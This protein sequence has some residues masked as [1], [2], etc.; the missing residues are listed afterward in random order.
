MSEILSR[1]Q[2]IRRGK[3]K[4]ILASEAELAAEAPVLAAR[5]AE[6]AQF[7]L[8]APLFGALWVLHALR[9]RHPRGWW[10][11][12]RRDAVAPTAWA[13]PWSEIPSF[14]WSEEELELLKRYPTLGELLNHRAFRATPEAVHRALLNWSTG[15]Y[16]MVLMDRIPSV[17]EVLA[18]QITGKRC[19]TLL[20]G[21]RQLAKLVLG[22]RDPLSFAY[23]DL[24]HADH[25]FHC[26]DLRL[27]QVGFYRQ[28]HHLLEAGLLAP[29]LRCENFQG[30]LEYL[31][32]DMN[33]HPLHLW[34]CFKAILH[35][36]LPVETRAFMSDQLPVALKAQAEQS[37]ALVRMNT[38]EF[39]LN[40][41][42]VALTR[43]SEAW[44][45]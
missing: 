19:V 10:G 17:E 39:Q 3:F 29:W 12:H 43:W 15:I 25:F 11:A 34:K 38:P 20:T 32:A 42:G 36:N 18:Q 7:K 5:L 31:T 26:N 33:S 30:Q 1:P 44:G 24:I 23:H 8:P 2:G 13:I 40:T 27:G 37:E 45:A 9:V 35:M 22:E 4:K 28:V 16:P 14:T 21:E 41:D 6:L